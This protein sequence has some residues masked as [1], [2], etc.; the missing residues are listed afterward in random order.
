MARLLREGISNECGQGVIPKEITIYLITV[1]IFTKKVILFL[2]LSSFNPIV[3]VSPQRLSQIHH[4]QQGKRNMQ[5]GIGLIPSKPF[6]SLSG[7]AG[8]EQKAQGY[9]YPFHNSILPQ[10]LNLSRGYHG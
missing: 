9:D 8:Y 4:H 10:N 2:A 5:F 6:I 7:G 1:R 3:F